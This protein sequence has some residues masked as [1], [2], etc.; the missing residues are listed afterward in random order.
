MNR[1]PQRLDVTFTITWQADWHVGSGRGTARVDR[2]LRRR[3]WGPRG[4][5]IPFVPGSQIKGV[6]RHQC[7]RLLALLGGDVVSPHVV[8]S[9]VDPA[10]LDQFR[11]LAQSRLLVDRLFGSRFQGECL[12]VEDAVPPRD[13]MPIVSRIHSR[14][15]IDRVTGTARERTLFVTEVA[16]G[17]QTQLQSRLQARHAPG[18][19]TQDADGFPFEYALLLAGLLSLDQLGGDKSAGFG[20]CQITIVGNAVR[21]NERPDYPVAEALKSFEE[22]EWLEML[23]L[24]REEEGKA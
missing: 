7:E 15:A 8:G 11:P 12:F 24:L 6:L 13:S 19:L 10:L 3:V 2:L 5:R 17:R 16:P 23:Q 20:R 4:E 9:A 22:A 14:T 21:W 1:Q 18:T